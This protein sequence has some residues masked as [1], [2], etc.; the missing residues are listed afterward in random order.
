MVGTN[1]VNSYLISSLA[2][3]F[4]TL[5]ARVGRSKPKYLNT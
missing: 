3:S 1:Q 2:K 5:L 4:A